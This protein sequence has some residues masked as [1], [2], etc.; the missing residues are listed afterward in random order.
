MAGC[1]PP[2]RA[3][4]AA[5]H[6]RARRRRLSW[7]AR[8]RSARRCCRRSRRQAADGLLSRGA[9]RRLRPR[10][11]ARGRARD[12]AVSSST[13]RR[14]SRS[15]RT[16][17]HAGRLRAHRVGQGAGPAFS[18]AHR[19]RRSAQCRAC[20]RRPAGRDV[21]LAGVKVRGR[22]AARGGARTCSLSSI[23]ELDRRSP[24]RFVRR[25]V[26]APWRRD[27]GHRR[28]PQDPPAVRPAVVEIP[29]AA[30]PARRHERLR[31]GAP[32]IV[33]ASAARRSTTAPSAS[34]Q[35]GP[36]RCRP[37]AR[38]G[39]SAARPSSCTAAWA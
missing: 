20:A 26:S 6:H 23:D 25:G 30:A 9:R 3:G 36:R 28:V 13:A 1:R 7:P 4:A 27:A 10:L 35:C 14:A 19:Q 16:R 2:P 21:S 18:S 38:P 31:A 8:R 29:G 12:G 11:R 37:R 24:S 22:R 15:V 32:A 17:R 5:R 33:R 39:S 34:A